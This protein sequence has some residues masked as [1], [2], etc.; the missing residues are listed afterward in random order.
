MD[1]QRQLDQLFTA[2]KTEQPNYSFDDTKKKFLSTVVENSSIPK[3]KKTSFLSTKTWI[4]MLTTISTLT[5]VLVFFFNTNSTKN[6]S[7]SAVKPISESKQELAET[8]SSSSGNSVL[9]NNPT[10]KYALTLPEISSP[11]ENPF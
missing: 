1:K 6:E 10:D 11:F 2:A 3:A 9:G 5:A 7:N 4:I 8:N